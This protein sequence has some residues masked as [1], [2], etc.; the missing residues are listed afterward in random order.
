VINSFINSPAVIGNPNCQMIKVVLDN[1]ARGA[2]LEE[3]MEKQIPTTVV[4]NNISIEIAPWRFLNIN[5][6]L[7]E[8]QQQKLIQILLAHI[9]VKAGVFLKDLAPG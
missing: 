2:P 5:A 8:Q 7:N 3:L 1:E 4:H 9:F 6:N